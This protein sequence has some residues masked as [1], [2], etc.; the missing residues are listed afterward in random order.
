MKMSTRNS[1]WIKRCLLLLNS[2]DDYIV[3]ILKM[4]VDC[5]IQCFEEYF[6]ALSQQETEIR[7]KSEF[8][9]SPKFK[10][11]KEQSCTRKDPFEINLAPFS[12]HNSTHFNITN[13]FAS[14]KIGNSNPWSMKDHVFDFVVWILQKRFYHISYTEMVL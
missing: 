9:N 2:C 3:Q 7:S 6:H 10:V 13:T 12:K 5:R 1:H 4:S 8:W 11:T 14:E